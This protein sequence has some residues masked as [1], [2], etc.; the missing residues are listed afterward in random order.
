MILTLALILALLALL[1]IY[2]IIYIFIRRLR[3]PAADHRARIQSNARKAPLSSSL[4]RGSTQ[5]LSSGTP[6]SLRSRSS[7][8]SDYSNSCDSRSLVGY[9]VSFS[10]VPYVG[11]GARALSTEA[12]LELQHNER[13]HVSRLFATASPS[14]PP[15]Y[16]RALLAVPFNP[17]PTLSSPRSRSP[18]PSS[19]PPAPAYSHFCV[20]SSGVRAGPRAYHMLRGQTSASAPLDETTLEAYLTRMR[21][22]AT[23]R[24]RTHYSS[25]GSPPVF[26]TR[27]RPRS[28]SPSICRN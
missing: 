16:A 15:D 14:P 10:S 26:P 9:Q 19:S 18:S 22:E 3:Q 6:E 13:D 4:Y 25:P 5:A 23:S 11:Q 27:A 24:G 2:A 1:F 21:L 7:L 28:R 20:N 12:L 8:E 17:S